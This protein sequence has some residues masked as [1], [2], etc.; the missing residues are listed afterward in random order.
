MDW[1]KRAFIRPIL[2]IIKVYVASLDDPEAC[3]PDRHAFIDERLSWFYVA[4][5]LSRYF[6]SSPES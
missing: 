4:D 6:G 3:S 1:P 5:D 2:P